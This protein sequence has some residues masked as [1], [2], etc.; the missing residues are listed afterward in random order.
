[1]VMW[2]MPEAVHR[3]RWIE[4]GRTRADLKALTDPFDPLTYA[5]RLA[6]KRVMMIA[7]SIDEVVPPASAR[8]WNA[9]GRPPI[10]W[11]DCGH[12][13]AAGYLLPAI[14]ETVNF[15]ATEAERRTRLR[16]IGPR[17]ILRRREFL[18]KARRG[19]NGG[20]VTS[21]FMYVKDVRRSLEFDNEVVGA[22]VTQIHAEREVRPH[23]L[24]ILRLIFILMLHPQEPMPPNSSDTRPGVESTSSCTS[25]TS[26]RSINIAS[27]R[28]RSSALSGEPQPTRPGA[29][30]NSPFTPPTGPSGQS[31]R[32]NPAVNGPDPER[33][34]RSLR[35][36]VVPGPAGAQCILAGAFP[37]DQHK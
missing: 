26:T 12:Y 9:A 27:T 21:V 18:P 35:G 17:G 34:P 16:E 13:S 5:D 4:S 24:A 25:M 8:C 31:T 29:C 20:Q 11:Y 36:K 7:G 23:T 19:A 6:S 14:R 37:L 15:F 32:T 2:E 1:M 33:F 22:E 10:H 28:G 30:A 3:T